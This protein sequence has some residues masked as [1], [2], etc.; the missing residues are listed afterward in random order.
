[1]VVLAVIKNNSTGT[2]STESLTL[3]QLEA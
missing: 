3:L 2:G 1:L